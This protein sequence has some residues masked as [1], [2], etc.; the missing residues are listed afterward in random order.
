MVTVV[1]GSTSAARPDTVGKCEVVFYKAA[2]AACLAGWIPLIDFGKG[3]SLRCELILQHR[4]KH[5]EAIVVSGF[6]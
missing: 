4:A 3:L 6:P 2:H 5:T 1:C